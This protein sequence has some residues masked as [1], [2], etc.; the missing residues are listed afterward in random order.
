[1]KV[2]NTILEGVL[3]IEPSIFLDDR[4][5][6]H[7][8][9]NSK[10]YKEIGINEEFVQDNHSISSY[11]VLRGLHFQ[12]QNPQGKLVRCTKG[13]VHDVVVDIN[14]ESSTYCQYIGIDLSEDNFK[15]LWIPGGYAHGFCVLSEV[16][17]FQYKCT[18]YY[19]NNDQKGY[20]WNDPNLSIDWPIENPTLSEKDKL[21]PN[22]SDS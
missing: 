16:A 13:K 12:H 18:N 1:M 6:F 9:Y 3:I 10:I 19:D 7:E 5:S 22:L 21:L 4:G 8:S 20:I 15:Q 14:P 2:I 17:A 11:G